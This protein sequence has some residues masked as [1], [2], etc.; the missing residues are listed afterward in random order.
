MEQKECNC[1]ET[2]SHF[3]LYLIKMRSWERTRLPFVSPQIAI[4]ISLHAVAN[5]I[6]GKQMPSKTFHLVINHSADRV[7]EVLN[8]LV[9]SGW[10]KQIKHQRD[11]RIRLIEP[12]EKLM[13]L[14][15]EYQSYSGVLASMLTSQPDNRDSFLVST[16][17]QLDATAVGISRTDPAH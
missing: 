10:L 13:T 5:Y 11:R 3:V 14:M 16:N 6:H 17:D 1:S 4:D 15:A 12:T 8:E 2:I 7:R 9:S